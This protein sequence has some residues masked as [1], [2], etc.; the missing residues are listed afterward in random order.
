MKE[1]KD[2]Q[3][4]KKSAAI[5]SKIKEIQAGT[6]GSALCRCCICCCGLMM[7]LLLSLL[8][9]FACR[10]AG[11]M[12]CLRGGAMR[13]W[14]SWCAEAMQ[15]I[16]FNSLSVFVVIRVRGELCGMKGGV[17]K[18]C[19]LGAWCRLLSCEYCPR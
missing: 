15:G 12:L 1:A 19:V 11:G 10:S 14:I 8:L 9:G 17:S 18:W 16:L 4:R 2:E 13:S 3:K 7:L 5:A 6:F